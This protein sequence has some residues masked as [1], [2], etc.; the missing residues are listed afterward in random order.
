MV[1]LAAISLLL[2]ELLQPDQSAGIYSAGVAAK[3]DAATSGAQGR[4]S[5]HSLNV[6][7]IR[8]L[9]RGCILQSLR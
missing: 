1:S 4:M 9:R 8:Q 6:E 2:A 7:S 5:G 3:F